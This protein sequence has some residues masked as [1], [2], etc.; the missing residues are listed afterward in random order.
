MHS[1]TIIIVLILQVNGQL[2][3]VCQENSQCLEGFSCMQVVVTRRGD[4]VV[5]TV[6]TNCVTT[7]DCGR[8]VD[9]KINYNPFVSYVIKGSGCIDPY[10]S[11]FKS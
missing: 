11:Q 2:L 6:T 7:S 3:S 9:T 8:P 10:Q 4:S 1:I 5:Q